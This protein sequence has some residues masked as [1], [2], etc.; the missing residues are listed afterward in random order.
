MT[1]LVPFGGFEMRMKVYV[2]ELRRLLDKIEAIYAEDDS[3]GVEVI[4]DQLHTSYGMTDFNRDGS[5]AATD[6]IGSIEQN[7]EVHQFN[8]GRWYTEEGQIIRWVQ[9]RSVT[10]FVD[11]SR[12]I[13]G[14]MDS[15]GKEM[16]NQSVLGM[17]DNNE[18][19]DYIP[20]TVMMCLGFQNG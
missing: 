14:T 6:A 7:Y 15:A 12:G 18:Y 17:Y 3:E 8:T 11:I 13:N 5:V 19:K 9:V 10:Y 1:I 16:T 2:R 4:I 20:H